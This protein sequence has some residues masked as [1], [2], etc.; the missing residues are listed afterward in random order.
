MN[1]LF[2]DTREGEKTHQAEQML[3]DVSG[4]NMVWYAWQWPY[5]GN[6][7]TFFLWSLFKIAS[8]KLFLIIQSKMSPHPILH[9]LFLCIVFSL[10]CVLPRSR[11]LDKDLS[12]SG[13][14]VRWSRKASRKWESETGRVE[15]QLSVWYLGFSPARD[16]WEMAWICLRYALEYVWGIRKL[17]YLVTNSQ[18]M[19]RSCR[20]WMGL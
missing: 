13:L 12:A 14:H 17:G 16:L 1:T 2:S 10:T 4:C 6:T 20:G 8:V 19:V 3:H 7:V 11:I 18:S 15:S 9:F 5:F